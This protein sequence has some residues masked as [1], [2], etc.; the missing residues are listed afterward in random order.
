MKGVVVNLKKMMELSFLQ[1]CQILFF[2]GMAKKGEQTIEPEGDRPMLLTVQSLESRSAS[3]IE[4]LI[5]KKSSLCKAEKPHRTGKYNCTAALQSDW[6]GC[7]SYTTC[8][9][10]LNFLLGRM[11]R[12][13]YSDPS[14][15]IISV[16]CKKS[17]RAKIMSIFLAKVS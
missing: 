3:I 6:F 16:I 5:D 11:S 13:P 15:N 10:Q 8:E 7:V 14:P 17:S 1:K 4:L 2:A 12:P 9:L